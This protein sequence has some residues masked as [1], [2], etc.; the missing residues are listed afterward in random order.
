MQLIQNAA[1]TKDNVIIDYFR[2]R[3]EEIKENLKLK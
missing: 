3:L 2:S 1:F